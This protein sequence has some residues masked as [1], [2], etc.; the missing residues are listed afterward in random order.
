VNA[1]IP[2]GVADISMTKNFCGESPVRDAFS[3]YHWHQVNDA[4][5]GQL[6]TPDV[7]RA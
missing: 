2:V 5:C 6:A 1:G 3:G 4:D 7:T